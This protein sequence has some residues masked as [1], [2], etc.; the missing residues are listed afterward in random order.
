MDTSIICYRG[1]KNKRLIVKKM[2]MKRNP[3]PQVFYAW[4]VCIYAHIYL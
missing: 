1:L 4:R 3:D 2:H